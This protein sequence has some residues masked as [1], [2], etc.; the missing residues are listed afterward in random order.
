MASLAAI[1]LLLVLSMIILN[2]ASRRI[3]LGNAKGLGNFL[4]IGAN[5]EERN[6]SVLY[7]LE[8]VPQLSEFRSAQRDGFI[9]RLSQ[10]GSINKLLWI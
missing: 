8:T 7:E 9:T 4:S 2:L 1:W 5:G 3:P 10:Y 6:S